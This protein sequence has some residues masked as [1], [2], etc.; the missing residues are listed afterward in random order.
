[1][2]NCHA[3]G[4]PLDHATVRLEF[5][6]FESLAMNGLSF[7]CHAR[8][9]QLA[10]PERGIEL[11]PRISDP[12]AEPTPELVTVEQ[13]GSDWYAICAEHG[14]VAIK[15]ERDDAHLLAAHHIARVHSGLAATA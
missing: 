13:W 2:G 15:G 11:A 12:I 14:A 4:L 5:D 10:I 3:C 7:T 1:M 9:I 6:G 8:C